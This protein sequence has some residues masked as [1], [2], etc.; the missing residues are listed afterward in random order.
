MKFLG[1]LIAGDIAL[2]RAFWLIGIPLALV[3][4]LSGACTILGCGIE[5]PF[6]SGFLLLLFV[7]SSVAV[8]FASVAIWRSAS[9]YPRVTWWQVLAALGAKLCAALSGFAAAVSLLM[10]LY[11]VFIFIH[12]AFD[13]A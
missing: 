8:A 3:W 5:A 9:K 2:W 1:R 6:V 7:L 10:V 11:M 4:D 13:H 12:A